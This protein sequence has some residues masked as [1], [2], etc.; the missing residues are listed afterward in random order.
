VGLFARRPDRRQAVHLLCENFAPGLPR[1][2]GLS[3]VAR[4]KRLRLWTGPPVGVRRRPFF[5]RMSR[6]RHTATF[7]QAKGKEAAME[8]SNRDADL[9]MIRSVLGDDCAIA[10]LE[11]RTGLVNAADFELTAAVLHIS[12]RLELSSGDLRRMNAAI[13]KRFLAVTAGPHLGRR[14]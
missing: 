4:L 5:V 13:H 8:Y 9:F 6:R 10:Y 1:E 3:V 14:R 7:A 2:L 12:D 11:Y